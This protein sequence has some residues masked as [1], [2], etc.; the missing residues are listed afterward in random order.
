MEQVCA[1]EE[2]ERVL[3]PL[4]IGLEHLEQIERL[5]YLQGRQGVS[6]EIADVIDE[7]LASKR[8]TSFVKVDRTRLGDSWEAWVY[9]LIGSPGEADLVVGDQVEAAAEASAG[10]YFGPLQGFGHVRGVLTWENSD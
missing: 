6:A 9:V 3:C 10:T 5:P 1:Q 7:V 2:M 8:S 4:D